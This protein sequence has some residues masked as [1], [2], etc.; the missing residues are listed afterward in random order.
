MTLTLTIH[1]NTSSF[2]FINKNRHHSVAVS[3]LLS[4]NQ[5]ICHS[6]N[7]N[8]CKNTNYKKYNYS[9]IAIG[10]IKLEDPLSSEEE[11]VSE[12]RQ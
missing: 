2:V 3:W 9:A 10:N 11:Y 7:Y 6:T 4:F 5:H 8:K 12:S 1:L